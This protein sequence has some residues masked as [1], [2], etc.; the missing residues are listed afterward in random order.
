MARPHFVLTAGARQDLLDIE[1]YITYRDGELRAHGVLIRI[2]GLMGR[3]A[4]NPRI[5][6]CREDLIGKPLSFPVMS[7]AIYYE[8]IP[9]G[10]RILRIIS[11]RRDIDKAWP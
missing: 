11:T 7:W 5:G 9:D 2:L 3:L 6:R 4:Y 8:P 10:V 1:S